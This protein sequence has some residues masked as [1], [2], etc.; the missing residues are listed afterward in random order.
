MDFA[1]LEKIAARGT[2]RFPISVRQG[3]SRRL[4][5][6]P[7]RL[8][9]KDLIDDRD[10]DHFSRSYFLKYGPN[11]IRESNSVGARF[12]FIF[13]LFK[14]LPACSRIELH[15]FSGTRDRLDIM[16]TVIAA[17]LLGIPV[18][19]HDYRFISE[20]D[21]TFSRIIYPLIRRLEIGDI[22]AVG[23]VG[24]NVPSISFRSELA[25]MSRYRGF[26][27]EKAVPKVLVY[28]DFES[29]K[30]LSLVGRTHELI[31]QKYPRTEF[32]LVSLTAGSE[33]NM[34]SDN[35]DRSLNLVTPQSECDMQSYFEDADMVLLTS[36]GGLNRFMMMRARAA[37][38]PV[39]T[40]GIE[41]QPHDQKIISVVRDSYSGL[42]EAVIGLV[43]D[44][45]Y[46]REFA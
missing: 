39:I 37:G 24:I 11:P 30:I 43:D 17:G 33:N 15:L 42:A 6:Y 10:D 25:D 31:K 18:D 29:R 40:N 35:F 19:L 9:F 22:S 44:E 16:M 26:R 34:S 1:F 41:Y 32:A 38:Y 7:A 21:L 13:S 28:G 45:S 20:R 4:V 3:I 46:Y 8:Q 5:I 12:R 36:H 2:G 27:K 14:T 23:D